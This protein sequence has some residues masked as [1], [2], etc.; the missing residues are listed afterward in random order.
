MT[1]EWDNFKREHVRRWL[2]HVRACVSQMR[3][4]EDAMAAERDRY[5]MLKAI[6]YDRVGGKC[7]PVTGDESIVSHIQ[8]I[9][10]ISQEMETASVEY[11]GEVRFARSVFYSLTCHDDAGSLMDYHYIQ[12]LTWPDAAAKVGLAESWVKWIASEA[13]LECYDLM[14]IEYRE[15]IPRADG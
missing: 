14:P 15:R 10:D 13:T 6:R 2:H 7:L 9:A 8:R 1:D 3:S 4:L 12:R 11:A 5:D